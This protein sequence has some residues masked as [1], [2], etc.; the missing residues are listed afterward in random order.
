MSKSASASQWRNFPA[1]L[2]ASSI[3]GGFAGTAC[4]TALTLSIMPAVT[5]TNIT[6]E[7]TMGLPPA[8]YTR[9]M[10]FKLAFLFASSIS[11][12]ATLVLGPL[13]W[14]LFGRGSRA[15]PKFFG[16]LGFIAG[17]LLLLI[18]AR[19]TNNSFLFP[20]LGAFPGLAGGAVFA[21]C[22]RPVP[23]EE[24]TSPW[25]NRAFTMAAAVVG[26]YLLSLVLP[27]ATPHVV[28]AASHAIDRIAGKQIV[29]LKTR[30]HWHDGAALRGE[31]IKT[32]QLAVPPSLHL[33]GTGSE[34]WSRFTSEVPVYGTS[35]REK[36]ARRYVAMRTYLG[37][38]GDLASDGPPGKMF[39][40]TLTNELPGLVDPKALQAAMAQPGASARCVSSGNWLVYRGWVVRLWSTSQSPQQTCAMV[41][42]A[43]D[44]WTVRIDDLY[45][46]DSG[47][48]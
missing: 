6:P 21:H 26:L 5:P 24:R 23:A 46:K 38:H 7:V 15:T 45:S 41:A 12:I 40:L 1:A 19:A 43:L 28:D 11:F 35:A 3:V 30:M 2:G 42:A 22:M 32:W 48:P 31:R 29:T 37:P 36:H 20:L 8:L 10:L 27:S 17:Y 25:V 34:S 13:L 18:L 14:W 39:S 4:V 16:A 33:T 47:G 44:R 9:V